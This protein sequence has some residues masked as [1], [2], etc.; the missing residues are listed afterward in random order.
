MCQEQA[1]T[2][3]LLKYALSGLEP[4]A[5]LQNFR[6]YGGIVLTDATDPDVVADSH[7][8]LRA[9]FADRDAIARMPYD[10][11]LRLGYTPPGREGFQSDPDR[12]NFH[13]EAMD[14]NPEHQQVTS[15]IAALY[16]Q[17]EIDVA[18]RVIDLLSHGTGLHT[19][20]VS[21]GTHILRAARYLTP[22]MT[23][24]DIMFDAHR[25]FGLLTVFIGSGQSGLQA[26]VKGSFE[27]IVLMPGDVLVGVGT[28]LAQFLHEENV[29]ALKHRVVGG[30]EDRLSA[31]FF[32]E[33]HS[34]MILPRTKERSGDMVNRIM[35]M[36]AGNG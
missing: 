36:V 12:K 32:Y 28:Q 29:R 35:D 20:T 33:L 1:R 13:R 26:D 3:R 14:L 15:S 30:E 21:P 23:R 17:V 24:D 19:D 9:L 5:L 7:R 18:Q 11:Q 6:K 27:D 34:D 22:G 31:F 10:R 2:S 4:D 8:D 16:R 25:D